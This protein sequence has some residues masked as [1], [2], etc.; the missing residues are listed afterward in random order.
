MGAFQILNQ[1][2]NSC[3]YSREPW[4]IIAE[5]PAYPNRLEE[6]HRT[7]GLGNDP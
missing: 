7:L 6:T 5:S 1:L 4:G 3:I 2:L